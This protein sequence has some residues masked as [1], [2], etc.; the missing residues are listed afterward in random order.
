MT[1]GNAR[2]NDKDKFN[3]FCSYASLVTASTL[4]Y[5]CLTFYVKFVRKSELECFRRVCY[6]TKFHDP[7]IQSWCVCVCVWCVWCVVCVVCVC[8]WCVCVWCVC[9]VCVFVCVVCVCVYLRPLMDSL[10]IS[11]AIFPAICKTSHQ[12]AKDRVWMYA[13][14]KEN[15]LKF[16]GPA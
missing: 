3:L 2:C 1:V 13:L 16:H 9:V 4:L 14:K 10:S 7:I 8:V 5:C 11:L 12:A 6:H 15:S